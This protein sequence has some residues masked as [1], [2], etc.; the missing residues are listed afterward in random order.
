M[1]RALGVDATPLRERFPPDINDVDLFKALS[2]LEVTIVGPDMRQLTRSHEAREL[3]A[4]GI[5]AVYFGPF[6][7]KFELWEQAAW[8]VRR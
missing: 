4:A 5:S 7:S 6:Y 2:G 8:L 1:L 3:K